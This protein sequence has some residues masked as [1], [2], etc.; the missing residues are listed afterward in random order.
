MKT[1]KRDYNYSFLRGL[2]NPGETRYFKL[3]KKRM[4]PQVYCSL[5]SSFSLLGDFI[6]NL[7]EQKDLANRMLYCAKVGIMTA[8]S[9]SEKQSYSK[10]EELARQQIFELS[11]LLINQKKEEEKKR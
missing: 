5:V 8:K 4:V 10:L 3:S 9:E 11:K 6:M 7:S 2:K 1:Y